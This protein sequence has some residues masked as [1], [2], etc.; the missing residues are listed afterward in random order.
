MWPDQELTAVPGSESRRRAARWLGAIE[1]VLFVTAVLSLGW[2]A[3]VQI[4]A[5]RDQATWARELEEQWARRAPASSPTEGVR[6]VPVAPRALV[7]RIDI[8]RLGL[9]AV[10]R[11]G[12]DARTLRSAVGHIPE[13]ALPGEIGNAAFAGHRDT[14]FR[15]LRNVRAGDHV[16]V[17]GAD[18]EVQL[19]VV[20]DTRIVA[21]TDVSPLAHTTEPT[22]T[23][24]T[25]YP[26]DYIGSA[27]KRFVVRATK[28]HS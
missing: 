19:Y 15:E 12:V 25:C 21:P 11:E 18:G 8:P 9:S 27:P 13:T 1:A 20:R 16:Y 24:V 17:R 26:F 23:L 4:S 3:G 7:G 6:R 2:Y 5:A 10:V 28:A 22:V 14:F